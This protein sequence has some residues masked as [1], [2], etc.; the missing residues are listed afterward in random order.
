MISVGGDTAWLWLLRRASYPGRRE[1]TSPSAK[2]GNGGI[3]ARAAATSWP[4]VREITSSSDLCRLKGLAMDMTSLL[5]I[6]MGCLT[7]ALICPA[8]VDQHIASVEVHS[9]LGK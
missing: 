4:I 7:E 8:G 2:T 6:L 9:R 5:S 1:E 3:Y